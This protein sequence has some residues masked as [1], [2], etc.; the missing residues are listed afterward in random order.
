M[1]FKLLNCGV[2]KNNF[3]LN[4]T[5]SGIVELLPRK[6]PFKRHYKDEDQLEGI[7]F[8]P[9]YKYLGTWITNKLT[10]DA[11]M[12]FIKKK[13]DIL[14]SRGQIFAKTEFLC[15]K[16]FFCKSFIFLCKNYFFLCKDYLFFCNIFFSF[17]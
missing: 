10:L 5:K 12:E 8:L 2:K 7:H 16:K 1:L 6:G 11:Q 13:A 9:K 3:S 14:A 17:L 15:K 4:E